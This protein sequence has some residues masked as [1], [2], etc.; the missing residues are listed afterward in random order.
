MKRAIAA[1]LSLV[2]A[3]NGLAMLFAARWWYG[4]VP[5]VTA[6]GPFN[7]HFVEDIGAAYLAAA[8]ALALAA[9]RPAAG[10]GAAAGAAAF[11]LL[12]AGIHLAAVAMGAMPLT[13][14]VR[15]STRTARRSCGAGALA[16]SSTSA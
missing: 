14:L 10:R 11:L 2:L 5:G 3:A 7:H 16:V 1:V 9:V 13:A 6:T 12:H 8:G 4:L 15:D